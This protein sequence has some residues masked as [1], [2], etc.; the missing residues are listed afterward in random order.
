MGA[1]IGSIY[2]MNNLILEKDYRNIIEVNYEHKVLQKYGVL[3]PKSLDLMTPAELRRYKK[4][5]ESAVKSATSEADKNVLNLQVSQVKSRLKEDAQGFWEK[6]WGGMITLSGVQ[7]STEENNKN[8]PLNTD[9]D[10]T[11]KEV[12]ARKKRTKRVLIGV[13]IGVGVLLVGTVTYLALR[14]K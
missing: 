6:I 12:E 1:I 7:P 11:D 5:L 9:K 10:S 4:V 3:P 8:L 2:P 14:K 13:G